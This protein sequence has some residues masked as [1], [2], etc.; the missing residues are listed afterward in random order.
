MELINLI[1]G[2]LLILFGLRFLRKGFARI[3]G[4][5]LVDWL[6]RFTRTSG[7]ALAGGVVSG[8]VMPSSTATAMLSVQMTRRGKAPWKN[9]L[10]VLLGAQ[11]G[12]TVLVHVIS[13][14]L[15]D[16]VGLFVALGAGLFLFVE[17]GRPRGVGQA[18]LAFG[19]ML[20]GMSLL[21]EAA[22]AL[23]AD[24]AVEALFAALG[25]LPLLFLIGA[26]LLTLMVQSATAS[27]ALALALV[28][29]GQIT[30]TLLLLWVLGA[31][32]GLSL[33][34]LLAGWGDPQGRRL[35]FA[36][37]LV[38]LPL[39][40]LVAGFLAGSGASLLSGLPG[41][42]PQ[43]AAWTHTLF[44]L[45]ACAALLFAV[46]LERWVTQ[47]VPDTTPAAPA[48]PASLPG[49]DPLL[50]QNP[51]LAVNAALRETLRIFDALHLISDAMVQGV[52]EG[53][54]AEDFR[55]DLK[56]RSR[57]ITNA[58]QEL[59]AFLDA[60]PDDALKREDRALKETIDDFMRELPMI[61]RTLGPDCHDKLQRLLR[62]PP[63]AIERA[64]PLLLEASARFSKQLNTVARMLMRERPELGRKILERKQD[65][66][67]WLI[68]AKRTT[69]GLSYPA[70]EIL[71]GFQQLNRRL[72]GVAY[73]YCHDHLSGEDLDAD[74]SDPQSHPGGGDRDDDG[75]R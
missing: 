36:V 29:S 67:S 44:N 72:S 56:R 45:I 59:T 55:E 14:S 22:A 40:L 20:L 75:G 47:L 65:N 39:A 3:I 51:A 25:Q 12:T 37:L 57:E 19:F 48:G 61:L 24:P 46:P 17:A 4:G 30:L 9:V 64:R 38:K 27:I 50:L 74:V 6:Q 71:D 28:A 66:S 54:V 16:Y 41:E 70:W 35:G 43:H 15:H 73:V 18:V 26:I 34:V 31:N 33:T 53:E 32:I 62:L 5:D 58:A 11:L 69:P 1:A 49:L 42:L 8:T 21:S 60:I 13:F 7:R 52:R 10:A 23:G 2:V 63:P 68:R